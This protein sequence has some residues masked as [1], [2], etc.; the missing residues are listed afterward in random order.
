MNIDHL[1]LSS[2]K[3]PVAQGENVLLVEGSLQ[4]PA[5]RVES[6]KTAAA[7]TTPVDESI[8]RVER[9]PSQ[10]QA[11]ETAIAARSIPQEPEPLVAARR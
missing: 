4:S 11:A 1:L 9:Q 6:L 8:A 3:G 7:A 2:A 5:C 10:P